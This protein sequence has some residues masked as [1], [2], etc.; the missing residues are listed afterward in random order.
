MAWSD[1]F[2]HGRNISK[3][4]QMSWYHF[5]T[6]LTPK[7]AL[8]SGANSPNLNSLERFRRTMPPTAHTRGRFMWNLATRDFLNRK[9][10][11]SENDLDSYVTIWRNGDFVESFGIHFVFCHIMPTSVVVTYTRCICLPK[12][13]LK[14][15]KTQGALLQYQYWKVDF[16]DGIS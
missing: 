8:L 14:S 15:L 10:C 3:L 11:G 5:R 6:F 12:H 16:V 9:I 1:Y 4:L 13:S 2:V 7:N